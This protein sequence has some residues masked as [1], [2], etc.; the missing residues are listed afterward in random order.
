MCGI[1]G[2]HRPG[3]PFPESVSGV[4]S[5]LAAM[6]HRGPDAR[7]LHEVDGGALGAVRLAVIDLHGGDQPLFNEDRSVV[8]VFNGE[9]YN[10]PELFRR[11][12]RNGHQLS[13]RADSEVIAHLY[14]DLGVRGLV[15]E[16]DGMFAFAL[17]DARRQRLHLVRDRFGVKPLHWTWDGTTLAFASEVKAMAAAGVVRP[18]LDMDAWTELLTFQNILSDR[19]LFDGVRLLPPGSVLTLDAEGPRVDRFWDAYPCPDPSLRAGPELEEAVRDHF[20]AGVRRQLV[21]DVEV[22]AYLSGGLDTGSVAAV[23]AA[24]LPRLTT[25]ATGFDLS[26]ATGM[27]ATFDERSDARQLAG[28]LGTHHKE[29]LLDQADLPMILPRLVRAIEEPRLSFSYPNYLTA[30]MAS[31]WVK[32]VLSGAGGDE[33]FG[34]YP[35]R[36]ESAARPDWQAGY[37]EWW[38]RLLTPASM[39]ELLTDEARSQVDLDRPRRVFNEI[40]DRVDGAAPLDAMLYLEFTTYL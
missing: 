33:V 34:G 7:G 12:R 27:E 23:A 20:E 2:L 15:A 26:I 32:V 10:H 31:R 9:I 38:Q 30:G 5:M 39:S 19:S 37:F 28:T 17:W 8:V 40:L 6:H 14:E 24:S 22:A 3:L 25:F 13:S 36:Y 29:L 4:A 21:A 16:L 18:R 35:W 1:A 11:L